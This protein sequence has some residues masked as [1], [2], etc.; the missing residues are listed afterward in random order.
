MKHSNSTFTISLKIVCSSSRES[1]WWYLIPSVSTLDSLNL[2]M[3]SV[4]G[5]YPKH[6]WVYLRWPRSINFA[7][8][9]STTWN[10]QR[11]TSYLRWEVNQ[12]LKVS[13]V[14]CGLSQNQNLCLERT[15]FN[16]W[17]TVCSWKRTTTWQKRTLSRAAW[18]RVP[19]QGCRLQTPPLISRSSKR[20][21]PLSFDT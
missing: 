8:S 13:R 6:W 7:L 10:Y 5:S 14:Q 16:V 17:Q 9:L 19:L 4:K 11:R 3:E 1:G 12:T 21:L 20:V 2:G 18:L 15:C